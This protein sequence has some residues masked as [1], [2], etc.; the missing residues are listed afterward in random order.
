MKNYK[1]GSVKKITPIKLN[2]FTFWAKTFV[3]YKW[4]SIFWCTRILF[5]FKH[6][7]SIFTSFIFN[8][9]Y[10][11]KCITES[12][13]KRVVCFW[14]RY[15]FSCLLLGEFF[16]IC[17]PSGSDPGLWPTAIEITKFSCKFYRLV[18]SIA[19]GS[20]KENV[21]INETCITCREEADWLSPGSPGGP[22]EQQEKPVVLSLYILTSCCFHNLKTKIY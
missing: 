8:I 15:R 6:F 20:W 17:S 12:Y 16:G 22:R 18:I 10:T 3:T 5:R 7:V 13:H 4:F 19:V 14:M 2:S 11:R 9:C 21:S 1:K